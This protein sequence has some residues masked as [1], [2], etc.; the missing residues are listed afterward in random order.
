MQR[1]T[2]YPSRGRFAPSPSGPLHLGN[3]RTAL[4]A[5]L[6]A[7]AGGG[8]FVL[9]LEDLDR[10]R[11]RPGAFEGILHD[12][13]WLGIDWDEG[14]DIGGPSGPYRQS[15]RLPLYREHLRRLLEL[16]L[17]YPCY[18][19]RADSAIAASAP[20]GLLKEHAG[21]TGACRDPERRARRRQS[22]PDREP[23]YRFAIASMDQEFVDAVAGPCR[24]R[25]TAGQDDFVIWRATGTPAYQ[26]A[27]VVDDALMGIDQVA[28]G[29]DLL[30]S[31]PRQVALYQAFGYQAPEWAH[32]PIL[33]D[34]TGARMAKRNASEGLDVAR[35]RGWRPEQ[36]VGALAASLGLVPNGAACTAADLLP[37]FNAAKLVPQPGL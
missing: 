1:P 17:A 14:P 32:V 7:R 6:F 25:L 15:D 37:G 11:V 13:R 29:D 33:R 9:R 30:D 23:A 16:G 24:F 4:L 3:L 28:R 36:L 12:L 8:S 27:V 35:A 10:P 22:R 2:P 5:W 19:S 18:C 34:S 26:L 20:N 31:T 21:Y